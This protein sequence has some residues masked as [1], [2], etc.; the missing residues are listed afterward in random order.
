MRYTLITHVV[1]AEI[2]LL[3]FDENR[4]M[5]YPDWSDF[6]GAFVKIKVT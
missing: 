1:A 6:V 5:R 3:D 4:N 2:K